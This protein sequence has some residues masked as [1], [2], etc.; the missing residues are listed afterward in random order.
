LD[1]NDL[2]IAATALALDAVLITRDSD[3]QRKPK[4]VPLVHPKST[5]T[6]YWV[7]LAETTRRSR[8]SS[9]TS[10]FCDALRGKGPQVVAQSFTPDGGAQLILSDGRVLDTRKR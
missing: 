4:K 10:G 2:W 9:Y 8:L 7:F 1:E 5:S 6:H 3:F